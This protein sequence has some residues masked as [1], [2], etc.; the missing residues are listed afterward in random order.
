MAL[1]EAVGS[2]VGGVA[3]SGLLDSM[4]QLFGPDSEFMKM[5]GS[6]GMKNLIAGGTGLMQGMQVNDMLDFQKGLA[7]DAAAKTDVLFQQ[8][9]ED[10]QKNKDLNFSL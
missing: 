9:Q 1:G 4:A 2:A 3:S 5:I 10:R 8:D 6:E 7:T